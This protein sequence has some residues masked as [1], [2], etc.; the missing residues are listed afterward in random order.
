MRRTR[1]NG[2]ICGL[3]S[4]YLAGTALIGLRPGGAAAADFADP[5][6]RGVWERTD[7]LVADGTI[8]RTFFWGPTP[9]EVRREEFADSPGG[10]RTVQYFDK[11]RMEISN[12]NG[13]KN[14]PWYV[15]N[16]LLTVELISGRIQVGRNKYQDSVPA[17]INM[18]GDPGDTKAPTYAAF[19][20][21]SNTP[22]TDHRQPDRTG[23]TVQYTIDSRGR[24][25]SETTGLPPV[26]LVKYVPETGHNIAEPF[27][28]FLNSTGPVVEGGQQKTDRLIDP[29][30][31]A[32]GY[33][34]SDPY[35]T[36][37][38]IN[39]KI[40]DVLIQAYERRV[41]TYV[42]TNPEGFKVEMGNIGQHYFDWRYKGAG[43]PKNTPTPAP[44]DTPAP[45][46]P[47]NTPIRV[48]G[49]RVTLNGAGATFPAP[50]YTRWFQYYTQNVDGNVSFNYQPIG[51]GAGIS[52]ITARTVDFAGSD[53]P[54]S[55]AQ[56]NA[57]PGLLH[58][59]TVAGAIVLIFNVPGVSSVVLDADTVSKIYLG[60]V[61]NWNDI[62]IRNLNPG[63]NLPNQD[64]VVVHRSDGS[65]TT[66]HFTDYLSE[67]SPVW[68][69]QV[70]KGT[71]VNWPVGLG[72]RGN[73]GV[74]G[75][76][77]QTPYSIGYVELAY[78]KQNSLTYARLKNRAGNVVDA[79][80]D[81]T[82]AAVNGAIPR[83]PDDLRV[84]IVNS[85]DPNAWP[86][87]G[88]TYI[89]LYREQTDEDKGRALANFL[90]WATHDQNAATQ[91]RDLLYLPI[92]PSLLPRV[93]ARLRLITYN[94]R[95]I[96]P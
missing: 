12:P 41:L 60:D 17:A 78:A 82:A 75:L 5:A 50:I 46:A 45:P 18:T 48:G 44:T 3:L 52:Q 37:A 28:N 63:V 67:V 25:F 34:I 31:Y 43:R 77:R 40:T 89:L 21:V 7:K 56:L 58:V 65:G 72:A 38:T 62:E 36:K 73:A 6:F 86:I 10:T 90:W 80:L 11:S 64:I 51:S 4:L 74:A 54:L 94:G 68:R 20:S 47:T 13:D 66:Y 42:P 59:P 8:K 93:E 16:G 26:R 55:D 14:S 1:R 35:W 87:A 2:L 61:D 15:T 33:P 96:I 95:Q 19:A 69:Q 79:T 83:I 53:A 81:S 49:G 27:W 39:G 92:P 29:W 84:S 70:G 32:S 85:P 71:S 23:Q 9:G 91:A 22:R 57:A 24:V 76:V 30:F 88:F